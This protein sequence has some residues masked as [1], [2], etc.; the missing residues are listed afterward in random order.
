MGARQSP[1]MVRA[2]AMVLEHGVT[3]YAAALAC[4]ITRAAIYMSP[5]Y[6]EWKSEQAKP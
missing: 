2:K 3:P 1:Q 4:G 5:W 6:K